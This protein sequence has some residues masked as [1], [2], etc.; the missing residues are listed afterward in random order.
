LPVYYDDIKM[1]VG[2]RADIIVENKLLVEIKSIETIA[3]V[4]K[5]QVLTY[6][7]LSNLEIGLLINFNN[8]LLKD[9]ITRLYNKNYTSWQ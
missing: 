1:D 9:G 3:P 7:T 6:L 5:K 8:D 2:F 4:H